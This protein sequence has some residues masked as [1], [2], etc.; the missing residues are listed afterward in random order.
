MTDEI[1]SAIRRDRPLSHWISV[2]IIAVL[3][4]FAG[5]AALAPRLMTVDG[6]TARRIAAGG[7]LVATYLALAIAA[8]VIDWTV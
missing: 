6:D 3:F 8:D 5:A 2:L 4:V 1:S 7:I